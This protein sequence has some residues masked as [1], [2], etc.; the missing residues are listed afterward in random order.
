M[1]QAARRIQEPRTAARTSRIRLV[2]TPPARA[3]RTSP[4]TDN[5]ARVRAEEARARSVFSI[6]VTVFLCAVIMG[7]ARV[8][9]TSRA[10]E[11]ALTENSLLERFGLTGICKTPG[12]RIDNKS[13]TG[14]NQL[15]I[16]PM[17]NPVNV[18]L[19]GNK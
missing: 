9:L 2:E 15:K 7:G 18:I 11:Y 14:T 19:S 8:T 10:A 17:T 6:F 13:F 1:G 12:N 16:S 3:P 5:R 4:R